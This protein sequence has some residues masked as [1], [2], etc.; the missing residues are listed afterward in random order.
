M[1]LD[2]KRNYLLDNLIMAVSVSLKTFSS[3]TRKCVE[4]VALGLT[5]KRNWEWIIQRE[6]QWANMNYRL[7][8]SPLIHLMLLY[9]IF[10]SGKM[11][12]TTKVFNMPSGLQL[13]WR[14]TLALV[15]HNQ[16]LVRLLQN[17]MPS[18]LQLY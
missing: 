9:F 12:F 11:W 8:K 15:C 1:C 17:C 18:E 6:C 5:L 4:Y 7:M 2:F 13:C 14:E 3:T 10:L 16:P